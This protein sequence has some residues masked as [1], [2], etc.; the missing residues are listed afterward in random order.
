[1]VVSGE[2]KL[3]FSESVKTKAVLEYLGW[4]DSDRI[5]ED[6]MAEVIQIGRELSHP[7]SRY[8]QRDIDKITYDEVVLE[9]K[10]SLRSK[11]LVSVIEGAK[12]LVVFLV[13]IGSKLENRVYDLEKEG[14]II[15][16]RLLDGYGSEKLMSAARSLQKSETRSRSRLWISNEPP[17]LPWLWRLECNRAE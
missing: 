4:K 6:K 3:S 1:M 11:R 2:M 10:V 12:S 13:T 15:K 9:G 8:C 14:E 7:R 5:S 16:V 17:L